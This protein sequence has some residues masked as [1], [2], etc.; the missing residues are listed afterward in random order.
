MKLSEHIANLQKILEE[1]GD[2]DLYTWVDTR[3]DT[4]YIAR[5]PE[6]KVEEIDGTEFQIPKEL[7]NKNGNIIVISNMETGSFDEDEDS[8]QDFNLSDEKEI[9]VTK[10]EFD[11]LVA[12]AKEKSKLKKE[13]N[14]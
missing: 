8:I 2:Q 4:L 5:V 9:E 7:R 13:N 6:L 3:E 10:E 1:K 14:V 12:D 11:K